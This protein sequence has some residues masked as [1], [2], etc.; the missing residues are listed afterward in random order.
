MIAHLILG[1][2]PVELFYFLTEIDTYC[3]LGSFSVYFMLNLDST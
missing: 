2:L 3:V 1:F